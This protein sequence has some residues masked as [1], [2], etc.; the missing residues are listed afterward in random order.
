MKILCLNPPFKTE[1]GRFSRTSRSPAITKSGTIYYPIWLCYAAGVLEDAGHEIKVIDSCA[2]GYNLENT[3]QLVAE[4]R[5]EITVLDTSTPSIYSDVKTGAEIKKILPDCFVVLMGT[6]PSALPEETLRLNSA[7][8]AVAVGEADYTVR[9]LAQKL[10][11]AD[12]QKIQLDSAYRNNILSS[13]EGLAYRIGD[14]ICINKRR[15][16][17][18]NLDELPFVSKV[19]HK[20]LD[21][22]K[23]F[24]AASDYPEI[25]IMTA[26][27]CIAQ[28]TFCVY[29]QTIH[30]LK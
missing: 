20:H 25:Q 19:Y 16:L 2:S 7:I 3:L 14:G 23:Y 5:P 27:G 15:D 22:K 10:S 18:E 21:T 6:H 28:C 12:F 26:R 17:I 4:F 29:P 30:G 9:E 24:F 11:G 13:I 1:H 8:D